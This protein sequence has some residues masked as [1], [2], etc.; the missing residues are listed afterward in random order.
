MEQINTVIFYSIEKAI[1]SY[2][3]MAQKELKKNGV[4]ITVDQWLTLSALNNNP[5]ISQKTLAE[6]V[7]KDNASV[8]RIIHLLI[9]SG[10]L[11]STTHGSDGRRSKFKITSKGTSLLKKAIAV[12]KKYR[13]KALGNLSPNELNA[14]RRVM[15]TIIKNSR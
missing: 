6:L 14:T 1:K 9:K 4:N 2:R 11:K 5:E 15:E 10:Y 13:A 8:T 7:F 12:V 3:R